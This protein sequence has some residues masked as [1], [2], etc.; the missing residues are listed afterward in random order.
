MIQKAYKT[1]LFEKI[2]NLKTEIGNTPLY[3]I[4]KVFQKKGVS[5]YTK[6]E[7]KQ[8]GGSVKARAAY[9][10]IK[11]ACESGELTENK[12]LL[13]ATS[14]NTGIAYAAICSRLGI[15]VTLCVPENASLERKQV[16]TQLG[17]KVIYTSQFESTDGAQDYAKN[18]YEKKREFYF[19]A[20]QYNNPNNWK[21]HYFGT[22]LEIFHQTQGQI[23]HFVTGLGTTGTFMGVGRKLKELNPSI[24]IIALQPDSALHGLEG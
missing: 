10:I 16:L 3:S 24:Q 20:D 22:A 15:G 18:L 13:D 1:N 14:G 7:W 12:H 5:I 17:A 19:Y 8:L 9:H 2:T 11:N 23:T 21:A 4:N 6:L